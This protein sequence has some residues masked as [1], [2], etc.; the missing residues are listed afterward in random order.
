MFWINQHYLRQRSSWKSLIRANTTLTKYD[1]TAYRDKISQN[2]IA[3][4]REWAIALVAIT[5]SNVI[6]DKSASKNPLFILR[7]C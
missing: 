3:A 6:I 1:G 2:R 5:D 4:Q 7:F